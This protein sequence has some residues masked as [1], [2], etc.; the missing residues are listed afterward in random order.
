MSLALDAIGY[1]VVSTFL[2][3]LYLFN[4]LT[5]LPL[6]MQSTG[7]L[8]GFLFW[9]I[10]SLIQRK[11]IYRHYPWNGIVICFTLFLWIACLWSFFP[12]QSIRYTLVFT[13]GALWLILLSSY[14]FRKRH[15]ALLYSLIVLAFSWQGILLLAPHVMSYYRAFLYGALHGDYMLFRSLG[16]PRIE[17]TI[18]GSNSVGGLYAILFSLTAPVVMSGFFSKQSAFRW[19]RVWQILFSSLGVL[20]LLIDLMVVVMSGSR[21]AFIGVALSVLFVWLVRLPWY[22]SLLFFLAG[23]V[24]MLIPSVYRT[25]QYVYGGIVD[26]ARYLLWQN[27]WEIAKLVPIT[28][29]GLGNFLPVYS[30]LF[31]EDFLHAHNIFMNVLVE[32]GLPGLIGFVWLSVALIGFGLRHCRLQKDPFW[33]GIELGLVITVFGYLM[34]CLVDY[35][36]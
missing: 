30:F 6:I 9:G 32:L 27:S 16:F 4:Q 25:I 24:S 7:L 35:T 36:I 29:V 34:R 22:R 12:N 11:I 21:G 31:H 13:T 2:V 14:P 3:S 28:G 15:I 18:G 8:L 1:A 33:Y 17:S 10:A 23:G 19:I 26:E 5:H 20:A